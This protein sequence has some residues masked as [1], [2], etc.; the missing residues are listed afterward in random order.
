LWT[1]LRRLEA[2]LRDG[3]KAVPYADHSDSKTVP[4]A[5]HSDSWIVPDAGHSDSWTVPDD[6]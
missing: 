4:D 1:T 3:L 6:S 2:I 5:D